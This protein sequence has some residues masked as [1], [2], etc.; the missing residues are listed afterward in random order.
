M[1]PGWQLHCHQKTINLPLNDDT[2]TKSFTKVTNP[3]YL[4]EARWSQCLWGTHKN[5]TETFHWKTL[6]R[7]KPSAGTIPPAELVTW[8][9]TKTLKHAQIQKATGSGFFCAKTT[10]QENYSGHTD[11][12]NVL[13]KLTFVITYCWF[14]FL[15]KHNQ[16]ISYLGKRKKGT[17]EDTFCFHLSPGLGCV[18]L[19][20]AGRVV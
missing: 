8:D 14:Y 18:S 15:K 3:S 9:K 12:T 4:L 20:W 11:Q 16:N 1:F 17:L 2:L 10:G 19:V 5:Y 13:S 6:T 7:Y